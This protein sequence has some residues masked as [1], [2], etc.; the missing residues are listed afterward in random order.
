VPVKIVRS[1]LYGPV[2]SAAPS[3]RE[4]KFFHLTLVTLGVTPPHP[5]AILG[6]GRRLAHIV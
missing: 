6:W 3:L 4:A 1:N 2:P 5:V